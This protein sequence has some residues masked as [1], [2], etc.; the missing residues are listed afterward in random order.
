[1][2]RH[3]GPPPQPKPRR[4]F[5][6]SNDERNQ[7]CPT[8]SQAVQDSHTD[9]T[10]DDLYGPDVPTTVD[11]MYGPEVPNT[12]ECL[13]EGT[14][15]WTDVASF[16]SKL[17]L[18]PDAGAGTETQNNTVQKDN[19]SI[20]AKVSLSEAA[21][22]SACKQEIDQ[23]HMEVSRLNAEIDTLHVTR[24]EYVK[25]QMEN[26]SLRS[27]LTEALQSKTKMES[28]YKKEIEEMHN[29]MALE[30]QCIQNW[31][32]QLAAKDEELKRRESD[33]YFRE[34]WMQKWR[35]ENNNLKEKVAMLE[36]RMEDIKQHVEP[37]KRHIG[38]KK[39]VM[40]DCA[41][42]PAV[43]TKPD[44]WAQTGRSPPDPL[45]ETFGH[46]VPQ[47][48]Y[49]PHAASMERRRDLAGSFEVDQEVMYQP[50]PTEEQVARERSWSGRSD[51]H[52][53]EYR[54]HVGPT[55]LQSRAA[56]SCVGGPPIQE[57]QRR[58]EYHSVRRTD[59]IHR[60]AVGHDR[61][62]FSDPLMVQDSAG[63]PRL[64]GPAGEAVFELGENTMNDEI[65]AKELQADEAHLQETLDQMVQEDRIARQL[66]EEKKK[67]PPASTDTQLNDLS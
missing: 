55:I 62:Q 45:I 16:T 12:A 23:M 35:D 11:D 30:K 56:A 59:A 46:Q 25:L 29:I 15:L 67:S 21:V 4:K 53:M 14:R 31:S 60:M 57:V 28:D 8:F 65:I 34:Q 37:K 32:A 40:P 44:T 5:G 52:T 42:G 47:P 2:S 26:S 33:L 22:H 39:R 49:G 20:L 17:T 24:A 18:K 66:L 3:G 50:D 9:P 48:C 43:E 10:D 63:R 51:V 1:M 41:I 6:L 13:P 38:S 27:M 7:S 19:V 64:S 61:I 58:M 36:L 54:D